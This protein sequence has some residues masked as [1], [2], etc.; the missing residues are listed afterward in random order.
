MDLDQTKYPKIDHPGLSTNEILDPFAGYYHFLVGCE[1]K[2]CV[3]KHRRC[4]L[5][6]R[7]SERIHR[8]SALQCA[9]GSQ[10]EPSENLMS[11]TCLHNFLGDPELPITSP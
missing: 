5:V 4:S 3:D 8:L 1:S 2:Q 11:K 9:Y 7:I 10:S 6:A